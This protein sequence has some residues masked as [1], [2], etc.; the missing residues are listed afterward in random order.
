M[1]IDRQQLD[2]DGLG[3]IQEIEDSMQEEERI[4]PAMRRRVE[5]HYADKAKVGNIGTSGDVEAILEHIIAL[6]DDEAVDILVKTI[7]FHR[8][9][10]KRKWY[11]YV[12]TA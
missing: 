7:A 3:E 9:R 11:H 8:V 1:Q 10:L 5:D 12:L 2:G 4:S 6:T